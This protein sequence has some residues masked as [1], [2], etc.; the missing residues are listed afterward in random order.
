MSKFRLIAVNVEDGTEVDLPSPE[1]IPV[2]LRRS[3]TD[4]DMSMQ[5]LG[6]IMGVSKQAVYL[7]ETGETAPTLDRL[8]R[9]MEMFAVVDKPASEP[10]PE[11]L[12]LP[13]AT[14]VVVATKAA[15]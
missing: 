5:E 13:H 1:E 10:S 6:A 3:R 15:K 9:L 7:W 4:K 12:L 2:W 14:N 11:S 8:I